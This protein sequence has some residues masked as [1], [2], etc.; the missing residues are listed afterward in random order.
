MKSATFKRN[1]RRIAVALL[2]VTALLILGQLEQAAGL[3]NH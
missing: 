1:A 3:P 2:I